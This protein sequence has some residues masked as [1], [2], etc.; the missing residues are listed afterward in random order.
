MGEVKINR[1]SSISS[2]SFFKASKAYIE[3]DAAAIDTFYLADNLFLRSSTTRSFMLLI[4]F[5]NSMLPPF[6]FLICFKCKNI[7]FL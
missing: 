1:K 2:N 5:G 4:N 3:K 6:F 7:I